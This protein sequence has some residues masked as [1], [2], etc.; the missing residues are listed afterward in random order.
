MRDE[1]YRDG[2]V[3]RA[4][5]TWHEEETRFA[6]QNGEA[7]FMR[8]WPYAYALMQDSAQSRVAGKFAVAPMPA[9]PG[10]HAYG[11]ARRRAARD[12]PATR[13]H[14]EAAWAVIDYLTQPEQMLE[15]A[16]G[17]GPVSDPRRRSTTIPSLRPAL[18]IPPAT[19][20]RDH[21]AC[22]APTGDAGL[23]PALGDPADP[24]PPRADPA[25]RA[26]RRAAPALRPRCSGCWTG[27][28]SGTGE[29]V[30]RR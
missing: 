17:G 25:G 7:A 16:R 4:V 1:I 9:G 11:G 30:A 22:R 21:R 2:I 28:G 23:H 8:N 20:R 27:P 3:P 29:P 24:A 14:P 12:Q 26:G 19:V 18:A 6:F 5:L 10:R 15:R 13:E